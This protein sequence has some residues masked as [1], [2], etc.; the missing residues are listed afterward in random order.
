MFDESALCVQLPAIVKA[1]TDGERRIV[2]VEASNEVCDSEGD[3]ILQQALLGSANSFVKNGHLD[4]DHISEIGDRLGIARP[5]DYI[6]GIPTEVKDLG[7]GRTGVIGELRRGCV[8][9]EELWDGITATPPVR[10]QAS[11][12]GFPVPGQVVDARVAKSQDMQGATRFLV[13]ALDWRSLAFTRHPINT[14]ITGAAHIVTAKSMLAFMK[15]R[16][17]SLLG[18]LSK[19]E[20]QMAVLPPSIPNLILPPRN[21]EELMG[22]YYYHMQQ[23]RCPQAGMHNGNSVFNFRN[24][25]ML[26]CGELEWEADIQALALMHLL[27]RERK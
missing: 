25:F 16:M 14:A 12:Y 6:V 26:C 19:A 9:A 11:I 2:E 18:D 3:V 22:H 27:K 17:P 4:I 21:R 20:D 10:W 7:N 1:H 8:K 24:H 15:S 13:K 5:S 23:G